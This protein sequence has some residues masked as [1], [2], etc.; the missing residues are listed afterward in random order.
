VRRAVFTV[1]IASCVK[2]KIVGNSIK[3][4]SLIAGRRSR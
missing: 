3:A 1:A 4:E 2:T